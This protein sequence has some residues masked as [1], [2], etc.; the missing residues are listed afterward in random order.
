MKSE[1]YVDQEVVVLLHSLGTDHHLWDQQVAVLAERY[2]VLAPD[3]AGH[4]GQR[5]EQPITLEA[6]V[7]SLH[8]I[9]APLNQPVHLVGLSMGGVQAIAFAARHPDRVRSLVLADTFAAINANTAETKIAGIR[10]SIEGAGMEAYAKQ[11]LQDT[12]TTTVA[13]A[14][15]AALHAAIS[16]VSADDYIQSA[17]A[18]FRADLLHVLEHIDAPTLVVIGDRDIKTPLSLSETLVEHIADARLAT[19]PE[20]GHLSNIDA[21]QAF[22]KTLLDFIEW[23]SSKVPS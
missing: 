12:L 23:A 22:N 9:I 5:S 11:Y 1:T 2:Q 17:E 7:E 6:W 18:T 10:E 21:P 4:G 15:S 19:V 16:A 8:A 14:V 20:A 13:P 3:S